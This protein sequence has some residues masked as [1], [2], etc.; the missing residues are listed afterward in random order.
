M[1]ILNLHKN[2]TKTEVEPTHSPT[3]TSLHDAEKGMNGNSLEDH[4]FSNNAQA[5]VKAVEAATTVWT[6]WHLVGAYVMLVH[7]IK[8]RESTNLHKVS[9]GFTS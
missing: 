2:N 4:Q 5:G 9:G 8:H 6:K 1:A 3:Q 7:H